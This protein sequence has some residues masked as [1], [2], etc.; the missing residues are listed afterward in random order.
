MKKPKN[1]KVGYGKPP[2]K[3]QFKKGTSGNPK[4]RPKKRKAISSERIKELLE[5]L[6][7]VV[8]GNKK[9]LISPKEVIWR[10]LLEKGI[11][12][13]YQALTKLL[14]ECKKYGVLPSPQGP[15]NNGVVWITDGF[16]EDSVFHDY[17]IK[18]EV[19]GTWDEQVTKKWYPR[20]QR[21]KQ[22][23]QGKP[24]PKGET[25]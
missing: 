21:L 4:G 10:K 18:N 14:N 20:F 1:Y 12:G 5:G 16:P 11:N 19:L 9:R 15:Q 23:R 22:K 17:L 25:K 13:N 8:H 7:S 6:V 2:Q 3:T 24:K